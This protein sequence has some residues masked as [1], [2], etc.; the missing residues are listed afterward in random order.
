M[1]KWSKF[2]FQS[3]ILENKIIF[4]L[5]M[6]VLISI[7]SQSFAQ[8]DLENIIEYEK[9]I[10][11][12]GKKSDIHVKHVIEFG[13]WGEDNPKMIKILEGSHSN[14]TVTDEDGDR[15]S[16]SYDG[17]TFEES[18]Y[19]IL[20][21]KLA[22]YDL[23]AEYDLENFIEKDNSKWAKKIVS[24]H[25]IIVM[26]DDDIQLVMVNSRPIDVSTAKGINCVGCQ[27]ILEYFDDE[28]YT[29]YFVDVYDKKYKI[30]ILSDGEI[31]DVKFAEHLGWLY[32][33]SEKNDQIIIAKIPRELL[34]DPF[35]IY[36]T[37]KDINIEMLEDTEQI[38]KTE[39]LESKTH[40]N[41]A[42]R[43][44]ETGTIAIS[45]STIEDHNKKLELLK[46]LDESAKSAPVYEQE[47]GFALP[48]PGMNSQEM[49]I[50][51]EVN[52]EK[53]LFEEKLKKPNESNSQDNT[54]ILVIGGVLAAIIIGVIVKIKKN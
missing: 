13:A 50:E 52:E 10:L 42:F 31:R 14:L 11:E 30:E 37:Q 6:I 7:P 21:Q 51:E 40:A 53:D 34:L 5:G 33:N 23:I 12:V 3:K 24:G 41:V 39:F 48:L 36:L 1:Q 26:F 8:E 32:F 25:D 29:E 4:L 28:K 15:L 49:T 19:I 22:S 44:E 16:F 35:K 46:K 20:N 54:M 9:I 38:R 17:D 47:K 27:M 18:K 43:P 45:G 2:Q